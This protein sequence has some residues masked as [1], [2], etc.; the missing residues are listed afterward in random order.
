MKKV[1]FALA[2]VAMFSFVAC[3]GNNTAAEDTVP[4]TQPIEE[5][6]PEAEEE[7]LEGVEGMAE[8]VA[9]EAEAVIAQ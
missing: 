2:V 6:V 1:F 5:M 9:A 8:D 3:N 7:T 4:A